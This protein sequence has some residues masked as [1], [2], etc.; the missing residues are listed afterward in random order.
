M[1]LPWLLQSLAIV[2]KS[3]FLAVNYDEIAL[4]NKNSYARDKIVDVIYKPWCGM[5]YSLLIL[6]DDYTYVGA[7]NWRL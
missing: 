5:I 6:C 7:N 3:S 1:G 4:S 2:S